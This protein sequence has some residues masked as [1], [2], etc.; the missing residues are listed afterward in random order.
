MLIG[1]GLF[2][3]Q[4]LQLSPVA[5]T[6]V[7]TS[8]RDGIIVLDVDGRILQMNPAA[9]KLLG[10]RDREI[11]GQHIAS[12]LPIPSA[13]FLNKDSRKREFNLEFSM[14]KMAKTGF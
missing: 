13:K 2:R 7:F 12:V 10:A 9:L 6:A 14:N 11:M 8:I 5:H 4:L 3:Y 1:L